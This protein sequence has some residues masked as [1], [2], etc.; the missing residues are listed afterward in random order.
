MIQDYVVL[1]GINV[2]LAWSVYVVLLSGSLSFANAGFMAIGAYAAS[3]LTVRF[4][5]PLV[6][7]ACAAG[8]AAFAFGVT[9]AF[10]ALRTRGLY[11][12]LVT[13]GIAASVKVVIESI[14]YVGGIQGLSGMSGTTPWHVGVLVLVVGA[15]LWL[16]SRSNLQLV[17][18]AIREDELVAGSLGVNVTH[19]K[20]VCFGAGAFLAAVAGAFYAHYMLFIRPDDFGIAASVFIVLYVVLGGVNNLWGP[21][22]GAVIMTLAPEMIRGLAQWRPTVFGLFIVVLL[23]VRP[24]GLLAFRVPTT[25]ATPS[26]AAKA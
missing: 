7:A 3:V 23:L 6:A 11:L 8:F 13:V 17:L 22:F 24:N 18:D 4:G 20:L 14:P 25:R 26:R 12:I 1:T 10:P 16:L 19:V 5:F 15:G 21:L 2:L 9:V